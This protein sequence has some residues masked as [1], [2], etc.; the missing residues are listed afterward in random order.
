MAENI[1]LQGAYIQVKRKNTGE[2]TFGGDQG[3]F[4]GADEKGGKGSIAASGCGAVAFSDVLLYLAGRKEKYQ[5]KETKNYVNRILEEEEYKEYFNGIFALL[6]GI[7]FKK[8]VSGLKLCLKFNKIARKN[9]W[10]LRAGWGISGRRI[11]DRMEEMLI[12]DIPVILCIPMMLRKK[13]KD[14]RLNLYERQPD[15]RYRRRQSA[16]AHYITV[17]G[18][19]KEQEDI[20][21]SCSSWG[22]KYFIS[23]NEYDAFIHNHFMGTILGN[24]L[25]I[26]RI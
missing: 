1:S 20:W 23:R 18:I 5:I 3:F 17:T 22:R 21:L 10:K 16:N 9:H 25:Y 24:V 8:G 14:H 26:R 19:R 15:G 12:N 4:S 6:G 2:I 7:I 13:D 11:H